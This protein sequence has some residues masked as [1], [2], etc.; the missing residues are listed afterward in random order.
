MNYYWKNREIFNYYKQVIKFAAKYAGDGGSILDVG[1]GGC[2]YIKWFNWFD[3][4]Y[5]IDKKK[6]PEIEEVKTI[7]GD[8][9]DFEISVIFDLVICLQVLEHLND[10]KAFCRKL[11]SVGKLIIISVPYK[12]RKGMCQYHVQDPVNE[13]KLEQWTG[14]FAI[15]KAIVTDN[16]LKRLVA[17]YKGKIQV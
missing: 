12:W 4:K 2:E 10:P 14:E 13:K 9:M 15:D 5:I 6:L 11:L 7:T 16:K 1:G 17:V 3:K 8:F